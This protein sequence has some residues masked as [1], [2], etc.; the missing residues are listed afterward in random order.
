VSDLGPF[1]IRRIES[2]TTPGAPIVTTS[3]ADAPV[4]VVLKRAAEI[5]AD[6]VTGDVERGSPADAQV[7]EA[8]RSQSSAIDAEAVTPLLRS[9]SAPPTL[10]APSHARDALAPETSVRHDTTGPSIDM[11]ADA[12]RTSVF[13][14]LSNLAAAPEPGAG[15][16]AAARP[17]GHAAGGQ[18]DQLR[19]LLDEFLPA[20][21]R[22]RD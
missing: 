4:A 6:R 20:T 7:A 15:G 11:T 1:A 18:P 2:S 13:H 3:G 12:M 5:Y 21:P 19:P 22:A 17:A 16:D 10:V 8:M 9:L 14:P